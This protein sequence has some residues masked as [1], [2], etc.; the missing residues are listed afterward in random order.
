M[1]LGVER[2]ITYTINAQNILT[3]EKTSS[4]V[5][6]IK[7][8]ASKTYIR[9]VTKET[10]EDPKKTERLSR[11]TWIGRIN[12]MA[13]LAKIVCRFNA[14]HTKIPMTVFTELGKRIPQWV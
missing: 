2:Q 7:C 1:V 12:I 13:I 11:Q 4:C 8:T 5:R 6:Y 14:F 10:E 9:T 3:G